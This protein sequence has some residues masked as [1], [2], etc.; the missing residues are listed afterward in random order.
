MRRAYA[1]ERPSGEG[2]LSVVMPNDVV[3]VRHGESEGNVVVEA[4][5]T[6]DRRHFTDEFMTTP[7]HL[8]RL[9]MGRARPVRADGLWEVEVGQRQRIEFRLPTNADLLD[10]VTQVKSIVDGAA[11]P[12]HR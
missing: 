1:R 2:G 8:W 5:K 6:D 4:G 10:E 9:T 3:L 12:W 7:G 11:N